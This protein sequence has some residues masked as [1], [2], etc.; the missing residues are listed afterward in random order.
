MT[1][2]SESIVNLP[3]LTGHAKLEQ[4]RNQVMAFI[5]KVVANEVSSEPDVAK[6]KDNPIENMDGLTAAIRELNKAKDKKLGINWQEQKLENGTKVRVRDARGLSASE[7]KL[8]EDAG[9]KYAMQILN[10]ARGA[11]LLLDEPGITEDQKER[12]KNALYQMANEALENIAQLPERIKNYNANMLAIL[13]GTGIT[14]AAEKLNF[15]KEITSFKDEHEHIATLTSHNGRTICEADVMLELTADQKNQYQK[16]A[17]DKGNE[18]NWFSALPQYKQN[19]IKGVAGDIAKG[20]K[21]IPAQLRELAGLRNAYEKTTAVQVQGANELKVVARAI[22]CGAPAS[23]S[24]DKDSQQVIA[25]QNLE[26]LQSHYSGNI[27]VNA[28][29]LTSNQQEGWISK[30]I[31]TAKVSF[32]ASPINHWRLLA[33]SGKDHSQFEN[34]LFSIAGALRGDAKLKNSTKHIQDY[35]DKGPSRLENLLERISF[36]KIQS[37][38][39]KAKGEAE[40]LEGDQAQALLNALEAK[41]AVTSYN[42]YGGENHNLSASSAMAKLDHDV[43]EGSLKTLPISNYTPS[44]HFCKSGKDRT[45]YVMLK[46]SENAVAAELGLSE[47]DSQNILHELAAGGHTQEMAGIQGGTVGCHSIKTSGKPSNFI[48]GEF[49]LALKDKRIEGII[50]QG[51]AGYNSK[52]KAT[53]DT[54]AKRNDNYDAAKIVSTGVTPHGL[55]KHSVEQ[56]GGI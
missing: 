26:Q 21:I 24:A 45:G 22:H 51:S 40:N 33:G 47:K 41:G 2:N 18:V 17:E 37:T 30:Q 16:I 6:Q 38:E 15:A 23:K 53:K 43:M 5:R 4:S 25:N 8:K 50:N 31:K 52:I 13:S 7:D 48:S 14:E 39:T 44:A 20:N 9:E 1:E 46:A 12:A 27:K 49:T 34:N 3:E 55:R 29:I 32:T 11:I 35:L 56:V 19:L 36:G 54:K 28:N 10:Q 42:F